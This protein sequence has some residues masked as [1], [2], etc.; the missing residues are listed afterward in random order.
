MSKKSGKRALPMRRKVGVSRGA[1]EMFG[2]N[3][4]I[5][6]MQL[7]MA[8]VQEELESLTASGSAGGGAVEVVVGGDRRVRQ[9]RIDPELLK[10]EDLE[11]LQDLVM[12]AVNQALEAAEQLATQKMSGI[13]G[14]PPEALP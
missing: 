12:V 14:I 10:P 7:E 9:I 4:D 1:Q 11:M 6:R 5:S 8:R 3:V 13:L 2:P